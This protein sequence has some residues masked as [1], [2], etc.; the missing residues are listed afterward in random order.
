MRKIE[1][2]DHSINLI[3]YHY[4]RE[5]KKSSYPNLKGLEFSDFKR[6]INNISNKYS[7]ITNED[8]LEILSSR[9][10]PRKPC[11]LLT[12][13]DGYLDHYKFVLPFLIKKKIKG[14]FYLPTQAIKKNIMLD[15][16]KIHFI[17]EKEN[18][19]IKILKLIDNLYKKKFGLSLEKYDLSKI[20]DRT[21]IDDKET[22]RIKVLFQY[23][24]P[25]KH[26]KYIID[27]LFSI[28]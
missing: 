5:I 24:L 11:F 8:F 16:N 26:R 10:F 23:L 6:Q 2:Q 9:K 21:F 7:I 19:R 15:V 12:F 14:N 22:W 18:D 4:V 25:K 1:I 28:I 13:D 3:T 17:L 27:R 20:Y